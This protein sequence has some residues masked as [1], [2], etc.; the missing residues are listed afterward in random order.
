MCGIVGI[1]NLKPVDC[2]SE[3]INTCLDLIQHRGPDGR[4]AVV[5][6]YAHGVE[7]ASGGGRE[8][9]L[10]HVRLSIIDLSVEGNQPMRSSDGR[11]WITYNGEIYNYLEVKRELE[12]LGYEFLNDTDTEVIINAY[13]EWGTDCLDHFAGMF[14]FV[15]VD[16]RKKRAFAARDRFGI[17]PMYLWHQD[18]QF[19]IASELKQ[20]MAF[21]TF[22]PVAEK[23]Q[24][25][26][27]L[28][29]DVVNHE[30][31]KTFFKDVFSLSPGHFMLWE[32]GQLPS[33]NNQRPYWQ[34]PVNTMDC[35]WEEAVEET[36]RV[37]D[38]VLAQHLR[39]DV[40]V[41]SCLSGGMDSS[42]LVSLM[43]E[44]H[45]R[46]VNTFSSCFPGSEID[47][48]EY[49]DEI[50]HS[51]QCVPHKI[52][53]DGDQLIDDIDHL[54]F[55]QDE[56]FGTL[57][58]YAQWCVMK[59]AKEAGIP[60]LMDGQGGDEALCGYR[61]YS[62]FHL[63]EL[64][65]A[66]KIKQAMAHGYHTLTKGDQRI[67]DFQAGQRYLPGFLRRRH[68]QNDTLLSDPW[69][70]MSRA[71][72]KESMS[73]VSSIKG[74]QIADLRHWSLPALLRYEDRNSMAHSIEARVPF[75][76]HRF[77]EHCLSLPNE[78]FFRHGMTKRVLAE[79]L[80]P[81]LPSKIRDR[82]TKLG[83]E[84]PQRI[85]LKGKLGT[86]LAD[87]VLRSKRLAEILD[88]DRF[89]TSFLD[90][91]NGGGG[92]SDLTLFRCVCLG[93]WLERFSVDV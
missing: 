22:R 84:T 59:R 31:D 27:F 92:F 14:A 47:E 25:I 20:F 36:T 18:H 38:L 29:D 57:S 9:G 39:S 88:M 41:G 68:D 76:D 6:T 32:L 62:F 85:W 91:Q 40:P 55:V 71:A 66:G 23:S 80:G 87:R 67:F 12:A 28:V 35:T 54:T 82:R 77:L 75:V 10:G 8:W 93:L 69:K 5:G 79:A 4:G 26:D 45:N 7:A 81:K 90:Y 83:F 72:W 86:I 11:C 3:K 58:I 56:P 60:V 48:Q 63:K 53:P 21:D 43:S 65:Q 73:G 49:I 64:I 89:K 52:F 33:L 42:C 50:I 44:D 17:K 1:F 15:L 13:R 30:P 61:K 37:L 74:Y 2:L 46:S 24:V 16:L 19:V 51:K 34:P 78:F 70:G